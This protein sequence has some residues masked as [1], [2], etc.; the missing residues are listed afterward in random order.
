LVV[1]ND[2]FTIQ[3]LEGCPISPEFFANCNH[4]FHEV[5]KLSTLIPQNIANIS[6]IV[7]APLN[8]ANLIDASS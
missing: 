4:S 7:P 5:T 6:A 3:N 2:G 8:D 1:L